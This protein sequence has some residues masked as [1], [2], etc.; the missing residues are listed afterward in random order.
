MV[1]PFLVS[2]LNL[3]L[4]S[5]LFWKLLF[6]I[7]VIQFIKICLVFSLSFLGYL[8]RKDDC[9]FEIITPITRS[10]SYG[11]Y[12]GW[13]QSNSHPYQEHHN[14]PLHRSAMLL[15]LSSVWLTVIVVII[16]MFCVTGVMI[17]YSWTSNAD[18]NVIVCEVNVKHDSV[19][20]CLKC[21][22]SFCASWFGMKFVRQ[23]WY[24]NLM[25]L[26]KTT[27]LQIQ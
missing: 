20:E 21:L 25:R 3:S 18:W 11:C 16:I 17:I 26:M 19:V 22:G 12:Q 1:E 6:N 7:D 24:F 15:L 10:Y 23:S 5:V 14:M 9:W 27:A 13:N 2:P 8:S 4:G